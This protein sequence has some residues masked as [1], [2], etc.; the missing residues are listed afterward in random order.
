M[1]NN[2]WHRPAHNAPKSVT[3]MVRYLMGG[4]K[5][6]D[7]EDVAKILGV[8]RRTVRDWMREAHQPSKKNQAKLQQ[9]ADRKYER[10]AREMARQ[11]REPYVWGGGQAPLTKMHFNGQLQMDGQSDRNYSRPRHITQSLTP[12]QGARAAAAY[13]ARDSPTL[14]QV[15]AE[16]L[17]AYFKTGAGYQFEPDQLDFDLSGVEF[18]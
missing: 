11:N 15:A 9:A 7:P 16:V 14:R 1:T 13:T 18:V 8:T 6:G 12:E 10:A 17:T 3:A 5:K 2:G 4:G